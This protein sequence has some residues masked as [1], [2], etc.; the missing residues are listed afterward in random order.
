MRDPRRALSSLLHRWSSRNILSTDVHTETADALPPPPLTAHP[1]YAR[2][3]WVWKFP[4]EF[5]RLVWVMGTVMNPRICMHFN[6]H[7]YAQRALLLFP[8]APLFSVAPERIWKWGHWSR[9]KVGGAP[10]RR[11]APEIFLSC[12][13]TFFGSKRTIRRFGERLRDGQYSVVS[14]LFAVFLLTVPHVPSHL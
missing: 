1:K 5:P 7:T 8:F 2:L 12:P 4:R 6:F 9:A 13:S 10:I 3:P 11:K 14:F